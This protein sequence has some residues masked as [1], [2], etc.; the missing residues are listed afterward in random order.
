MSKRVLHIIDTTGPGGAETVF[1]NLCEFSAANYEKTL[2]VVRGSGWVMSQLD[3]MGIDYKEIDCKGSFNITYLKKLVSL[4]RKE[5][6]TLIQTHLFGSAVYGAIAGLITRVPV[7]STIHGVVD[8]SNRER[9]LAAKLFFLR[10]AKSSL[11]GVTEQITNN[12]KNFALIKNDRVHTF[13]NGIDTNVFQFIASK[14]Q[15]RATK[16]SNVEIRI[17]CLGNI[18]EP[19][20]YPLA[21]RTIKSLSEMGLKARLL[22]AGQGNEKQL[23]PLIRLVNQYQLQDQ[24]DFLGFVEDTPAYLASLDVFLMT[25][26]SEGHP[27][28]LTQAM[29]IGVPIVTTPSGVEQIVEHGKNALV[30][31]KHD[32]DQLANSILYLQDNQDHAR[33]ILLEAKTL[34]AE[35]Y[36]TQAMIHR[37]EKLYSSL[38]A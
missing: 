30:S 12:L 2:A 37:Y 21:I 11:I 3:N 34:V 18:R 1:L 17:G 5:K 24:I 7:V 28:A 14:V 9:F 19:K 29:S 27:L 15:S 26:S 8:I 22:I 23:A 13:Y 25:S 35:R 31:G 6:I 36:S 16:A 32:A 10:L 33:R 20:N 4:V 38:L